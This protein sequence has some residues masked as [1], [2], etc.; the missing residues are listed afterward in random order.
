MF[1]GAEMIEEVNRIPMV[2]LVLMR[3]DVRL[4]EGRICGAPPTSRRQTGL[5]LSPSVRASLKAFL[6][7]Y[8]TGYG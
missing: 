5:S 2:L 6:Y 4:I 8:L 3:T 1:K 7:E